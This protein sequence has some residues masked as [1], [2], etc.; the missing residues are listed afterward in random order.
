MSERKIERYAGS[1]A[2]K[3]TLDVPLLL[4]EREVTYGSNLQRGR[5]LNPFFLRAVV[6]QVIDARVS[7]ADGS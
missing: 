1:N 6:R 5:G 7:A 3:N 2:N 4:Q